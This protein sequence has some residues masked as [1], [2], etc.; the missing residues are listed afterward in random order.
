[1]DSQIADQM[2]ISRRTVKRMLCINPEYMCVDGTQTRKSN[3]ILDPYRKQIQ[4]L[5]ERGFQTSQILK[6]LEEMHPGL[7]IKRTTLSDFCVKLRSEL[8]DYTQSPAENSES[9]SG[10]SILTPHDDRIKQML[11]DSK[12]ITVIF[13]AIKTEGYTGSYSLLQQYCGSIKPISLRTKKKIRKVRRRDL[14][15]AAW[16]GKTNLSENDMTYIEANH[17]AFVEIKGIITE[18][19]EAYSDKNIDAV[20]LWCEKYSQCKFPAICSFIN[21]INADAG[22]FYNSMKY[23]YSNGLLEGCVNKLKAVKRSMYGRAGYPLL[24]AKMLLSYYG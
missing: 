24:R 16:S 5:I 15:S 23:P 14:V 21:G 10:G 17:P 13:T 7:G 2:G 11:A 6:K 8:F 19:R 3:K 12:P 22:A 4:E 9:L 20:K 1:M 18:F